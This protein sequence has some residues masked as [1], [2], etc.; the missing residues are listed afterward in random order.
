MKKSNWVLY[1]DGIL[2][3]I[4]SIGSGIM[5]LAVAPTAVNTTYFIIAVSM[6]IVTLIGGLWY[7]LVC[8][9]FYFAK[10]KID[11]HG[12]TKKIYRKT[13]FLAWED[14]AECTLLWATVNTGGLYAVQFCA[15][16]VPLTQKDRKNLLSR[17]GK[18]KHYSDTIFFDCDKETYD[19]LMTCLPEQWKY[20]VWADALM[21]EFSDVS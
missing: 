8:A 17:R 11:Q 20:R 5:Y 4:V 9:S 16:T 14:C 1:V 21:I 19:L 6:G 18:H 13:Y 7:F 2:G 3:V 12:V 15:T 10:F